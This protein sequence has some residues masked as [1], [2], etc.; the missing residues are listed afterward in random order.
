MVYRY[1]KNNL[2]TGYSDPNQVLISHLHLLTMLRL[3]FLLQ[4][5]DTS[6]TFG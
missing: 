2:F 6:I 3:Y 5:I 4:T 1:N